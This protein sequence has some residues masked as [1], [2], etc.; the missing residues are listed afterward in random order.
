MLK[1]HMNSTY[2]QQRSLE[3]EQ[4]LNNTYEKLKGVEEEQHI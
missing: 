3:L 1:V 2:E 4:E